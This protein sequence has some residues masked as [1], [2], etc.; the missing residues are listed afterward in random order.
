MNRRKFV[1]SGLISGVALAS[2]RAL[3]G[4]SAQGANAVG[5]GND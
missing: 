2:V 1:R 3:A 4:N 5:R